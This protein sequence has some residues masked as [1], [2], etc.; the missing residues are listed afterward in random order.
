LSHGQ[1]LIAWSPIIVLGLLDKG[2]HGMLSSKSNLRALKHFGQDFGLALAA[3]ALALEMA[4][5]RH[6]G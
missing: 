4:L 2:Y 1:T 6:Q 5:E 3:A